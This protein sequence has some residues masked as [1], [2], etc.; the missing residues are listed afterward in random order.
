[1]AGPWNFR[2]D[3]SQ[4][5]ADNLS[6]PAVHSH[7]LSGPATS[8]NLPAINNGKSLA[9]LTPL[10]MSLSLEADMAGAM[11]STSL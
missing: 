2:P 4:T 7:Y 8:A 3:T 9:T 10:K 11:S 1:M 6:D 5:I